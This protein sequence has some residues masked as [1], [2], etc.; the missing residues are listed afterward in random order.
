MNLGQRRPTDAQD[1][2]A[3]GTCAM[4]K[5]LL[6][7]TAIAVAF[8]TPALA[9]KRTP[10]PEIKVEMAEAY[11]PDTAFEG[12]RKTLL[13]A[14]AKKDKAALVNLVGPTFVWTFNDQMA[15]DFDFGRDAQH[16]FKVA[17]GFRAAGKDVDGGVEDGPYWDT[18][19]DVAKSGSFYKDSNNKNLV[20]GPNR[21]SVADETVFQ[22]ASTKIAAKDDEGEW[23]YV[24]G[25]TVVSAS[26]SAGAPQVATISKVAVP[27]LSYYPKATAAQPEPIAT[28]IEVLLPSGKSGFVA[29]A[30]AKPLYGA[31]LCFAKS[32]DG[33]WKIASVNQVD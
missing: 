31:T 16:N 32:A 9:I 3:T 26:P 20:C 28:H 12:M 4:T 21:A 8:A 14:V 5:A 2:P 18:L 33:N 30:M 10:Y 25:D 11:K 24:V 29:I 22:E 15:E 1:T 7:A 17:F 6:A 27:V 13:M 23:Y 19:A